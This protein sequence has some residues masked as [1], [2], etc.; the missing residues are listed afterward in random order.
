M[1]D[2]IPPV[3]RRFETPRF[4]WLKHFETYSYQTVSGCGVLVGVRDDPIH[5]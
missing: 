5:A 2:P 3:Q 4:R 1:F